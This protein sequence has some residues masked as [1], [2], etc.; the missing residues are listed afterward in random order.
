MANSLATLSPDIV[1]L[2]VLDFL[3]KK[4]PILS[5]VATDFSDEPVKFGEQVLSRVVIPP[6]VQDY[7]GQG[8]GT[9]YASTDATTEDVPVRVNK[10]KHVSLSFSDQELSGTSRKLAD[11]QMGAA[12]YALGRQACLDL[13]SNISIANFITAR[14]ADAG[15]VAMVAAGLTINSAKTVATVANTDRTTLSAV[16]AQL[17]KQG[18]A[19]PR[20]GIVNS[21]V[22]ANL[23]NDSRL[24][25]IN[26]QA[27]P[28]DYENGV[29]TSA[30][31]FRSIMEWPDLPANGAD[32]ISGYFGHTAGLVLAT[33]IPEDPA[34]I[35]PDLP[36]PGKI[37]VIK[38]PDSGLALMVRYAYNMQT[39]RLL[40][41]LTW[42][43]GTAVGV[44][45]HATLLCTA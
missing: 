6:V 3:K 8:V 38:D 45:G 32:N 15:T 17:S 44:P 28:I 2:R 4:F 35:I 7:D 30:A 19:S 37:M 12:A 36:I 23:T 20:F 39:G 13:F 26:F 34:T 41:T 33:R 1:T 16:R 11:E 22:F 10:H 5:S 43:Y 25:N 40:M 21:D 9:G 29:I 24:I 42:M 31:G 27:S 18:A 14:N